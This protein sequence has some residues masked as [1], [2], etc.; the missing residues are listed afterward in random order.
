MIQ[1]FNLTLTG[2]VQ[3]L[4]TAATAA[5]GT[6][7]A[8]Q[9]ANRPLRTLHLQAGVGNAGVI[10]VGDDDQVSSSDYGVSIPIPVTS[11]PAAPFTV[12]DY[13]G[14]GPLKLQDFFVKG[15][16]NDV[17]HVLTVPF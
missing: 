6:S 5:T 9:T 7:V 15:T 10:Y 11:I 16:A 2:A 12:G 17:L 3:N 14:E 1:H 4:L 13:S 8:A